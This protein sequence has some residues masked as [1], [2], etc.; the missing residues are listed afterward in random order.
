MFRIAA[1]F[2]LLATSIAFAPMG[3]VSSRT[4]V[5]MQ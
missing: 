3:R 1:L 5:S 2:A 4:A